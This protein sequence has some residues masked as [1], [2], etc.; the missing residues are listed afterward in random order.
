MKVNGKIYHVTREPYMW[1]DEEGHIIVRLDAEKGLI[2]SA[3]VLFGDK[4]Q[5]DTKNGFAHARMVPYISTSYLDTFVATLAQDLPTFVYIFKI[6]L[7]DDTKVLY[8]SMGCVEEDE[9][10]L[11]ATSA[12]DDFFQVCWAFPSERIVV[13][14]IARDHGVVY[15]IFPDRFD[16]GDRKKACM[17]DA[18]IEVGQPL[19]RDVFT[20][21]SA[22]DLSAPEKVMEKFRKNG[23]FFGG[24]LKGVKE[25]IPY[26]KSLGVSTIYLC[27]I[28]VSHSNHRYDVEDYLHVDERLG[29]D[30]ALLALSKQI[31]ASGMRLVLDAVFNH[32]S[33]L[34]PWFQDVMKK[35]RKS[36][37]YDYY[38]IDGD[39]PDLAKRNYRTFA[40]GA[41]MPK[42][43]TANPKVIQECCSILKTLTER[44]HVDGWR[45]DVADE[46]AHAAWYS[47][48]QTL[49]AID[50]KIA[51]ISE[52]WLASD[53]WIDAAQFDG[54]MN[55]QLRRIV[56]DLTATDQPLTVKEA[57]DRLN[58]LLLRYTWPNDL[59]MFNLVGS[60]DVPR[61]LTLTGNDTRKALLAVALA[62]M[63]PGCFMAYYGDELKM[64]GGPD[65]DNR[66]AVD[67]DSDHWDGDY[68]DSYR[69]LCHL[70]ELEPTVSGRVEIRA[71]SN[72]LFIT[73]Y[74]REQT[75][76]LIAN[77]SEKRGY[78]TVSRSEKVL[79]SSNVEKRQIAPWGYLVTLQNKGRK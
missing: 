11:V 13:P 40:T 69:Q 64:E 23:A 68:L 15:Q 60:H 2:K 47:I 79:A 58:L 4:H 6:T 67:W 78:Y 77:P 55:Y 20:A 33:A 38:I 43:N 50:P 21:M 54:A 34:H 10:Q 24:D 63:F 65:P 30:R 59:A 5:P 14:T 36:P 70:K 27:P 7:K 53:N 12:I 26:L 9:N 61:I 46:I 1:Q 19:K 32:T 39:K 35:G 25:R 16:V 71:E 74:T 49:K 51:I 41:F 31:H 52:D 44:F 57:A 76:T 73:R 17:A 62:V 72:L 28:W 29:G 22:E 8:T 75:V 56:L 48:H 45:F 66:R 3:E 37:Y 18:N 42:L